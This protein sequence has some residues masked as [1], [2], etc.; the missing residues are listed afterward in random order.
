MGG[1]AAGSVTGRMKL[2]HAREAAGH[3]LTRL[4]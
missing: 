1:D 2:D 4:T 3:H